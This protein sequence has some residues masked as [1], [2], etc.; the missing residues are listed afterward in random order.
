MSGRQGNGRSYVENHAPYE[1]ALR[2]LADELAAALIDLPRMMASRGVVLADF[3]AADGIHLSA[4]GNAL[5]ADMVGAA[6]MGLLG[7]G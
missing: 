3:V 6:L 5:Y 2:A 1:R 7:E 4:R